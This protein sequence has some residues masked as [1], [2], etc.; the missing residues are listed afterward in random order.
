MPAPKVPTIPSVYDIRHLNGVNYAS[1]DKNQHLPNYCESGWAF[2][3][4]SALN[5][6]F[7]ILEHDTFPEVELSAQVLLNCVKSSTYTDG[8]QG[9]NNITYLK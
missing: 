9:G 8:C 1:T 5:D 2:A 7:A 4:T 6:R 3:A